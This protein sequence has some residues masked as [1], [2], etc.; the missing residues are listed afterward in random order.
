MTPNI[1]SPRTAALFALVAVTAIWGSTFLVV[2]NAIALV[3]VMDFLAL[4]FTLAALVMF[5]LRPR[6]LRGISRR[7]VLRG[8]GLGLALGAGYVT[9]T[10][11]LLTASPSVSGFITGTFVAFT[12]LISW[13]L[14]RRGID[15]NAWL[16]V[17]MALVGLALIS[18]H[19]WSLG[20]GELLTLACAFFF[21]IHIVGLGEWAPGE[22]AY[23]LAFIQIATVAAV[24]LV[25]AAPGGFQLPSRFDVWGAVALTAVLATALAFLIQTWAQ[26]LLS[27][28]LAAVVMTMEPV[29]AGIFGVTLGGDRLT[30]RVV[31]G[32]LCILA[33]ML[34][35]Q[36]GQKRDFE[37]SSA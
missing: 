11:G 15:R 10:F 37:R 28:T 14:H 20:S 33:A 25:L 35:V 21:A 5:A 16:G 30:A 29:F 12:P 22:T 34:V 7:G 13:V 32:A 17:S 24:S 4:R 36:L 2:K 26:S 31:G 9:Q 27:P 8:V 18:L 1:S 3:P 19:G 6:C 23:G